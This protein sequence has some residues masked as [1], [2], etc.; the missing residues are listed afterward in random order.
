[1][2]SDSVQKLV[3]AV[4]GVVAIG[5]IIAS[6]QQSASK[7]DPEFWPEAYQA[8]TPQYAYHKVWP[9]L[10]PLTA[11]AALEQRISQLVD[12][13][14]LAQKIGQMLQ[15]EISYDS[16]EEAAQFYTGSTTQAIGLQPGRGKTQ[17]QDWVQ[18]ADDYWLASPELTIATASDQGQGQTQKIANMWGADAI[19]G[20]A[21]VFGAV[22]FP[23]NI[24][25]GATRDSQL[26]QR[27]GQASAQQVLAAGQDML[28][29]PNASVAR[30]DRWGRSYESYSEHPELVYQLSQAFFQ[31]VQQPIAGQQVIAAATHFV[32]HGQ[33][34]G[35]DR[36]N[37]DL[38]EQELINLHAQPYFALIQSG[39][40]VIRL[41]FNSWQGKKMH[42]SNYLINDIL[43]NKLNFK[44][45]VL[46]DWHGAAFVLGCWQGSCAKAI[47]AGVDMFLIPTQA[48]GGVIERQDFFKTFIENTIEQ[49]NQGEIA[50]TRIDDAV[51]RILRVK[52]QAGLLDLA[53]PSLRPLAGKQT[54]IDNPALRQLARE[55]V[56][57]SLV[58]LKNADN[59]L[60]LNP[61]EHLLLIGEE[62]KKI[63]TLTGGY[64]MGFKAGGGNSKYPAGTDLFK[65]IK[66]V[67]QQ[68]TIKSDRAL[69]KMQAEDFAAF[70][71]IILVLKEPTYAGIA[72]DTAS[73]DFAQRFAKQAALFEKA[74][75]ANKPIVVLYFAG[76]PM[77]MNN[78]INA[79]DAFVAA[80]F[81]GTEAAGITDVI[82]SHTNGAINKG[83]SG[84]LPFSWPKAN[85][86]FQLN[87][88]NKTY[89]PL[90]AYGYGLS[91][92]QQPAWVDVSA[93]HADCQ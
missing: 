86:Q 58:L 84:K 82:F 23:H 10:P 29:A 39:L 93:K 28:Y 13:M 54:S 85:C 81:P 87:I 70:D 52:A 48:G 67:S 14:S 34:Q 79:S 43:K 47:N 83:F 41:G 35:I 77:Q 51:R 42:A 2:Q 11:D 91:Y 12:A 1:M 5:I 25:L 76:R 20:H 56:S 24:G 44:G 64:S 62:G 9:A 74:Q 60:P 80:W 37:N 53:K 75:Q 19:H 59:A 55:A 73:L 6:Q 33:T 46:S 69:L 38:S 7:I 26:V 31:G 18:L 45:V 88:G 15:I 57:K 66:Q 49:V 32:G 61:Q 16:A 36:G 27:I 63:K 71:K 50:L 40:P 22:I 17:L 3:A 92:G 72:G 30:D 65:Q 68:V 78:I 21:N 90:F 8:D 4:I 89:D